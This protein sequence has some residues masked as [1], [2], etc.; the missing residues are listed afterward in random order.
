MSVSLSLSLSQ[1]LKKKN[2][3]KKPKLSPNAEPVAGDMGPVR[4]RGEA[5]CVFLVRVL[6]ELAG[7]A[8]DWAGGR[9]RCRRSRRRRCSS[10]GTFRPPSPALSRHHVRLHVALVG[11]AVGS[12]AGTDDGLERDV[13]RRH[14][15]RGAEERELLHL[16]LL[17]GHRWARDRC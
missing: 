7:A 1:E 2:P 12:A 17:L 9:C 14:G 16:R 8:G 13:T 5:E 3:E 4:S 11:R 10:R 15:L 6:E